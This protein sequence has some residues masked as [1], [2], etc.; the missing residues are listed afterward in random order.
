M[1]TLQGVILA[2]V[3]SEPIDAIGVMVSVTVV[4]VLRREYSILLFTRWR[5]RVSSLLLLLKI[6]VTLSLS[7][8]SPV[9]GKSYRDD[10]SDDSTLW[11]DTG[12]TRQC[13]ATDTA[14]CAAET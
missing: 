7:G 12:V 8:V 14:Q 9:A 1:G 11:T 3:I 6:T 4:T 13:H 5:H 10:S 2:T